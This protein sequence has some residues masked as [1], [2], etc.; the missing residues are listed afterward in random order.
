M[1]KLFFISLLSS[2]LFS[3]SIIIKTKHKI[4]PSGLTMFRNH[5]FV[6]S[7]NGR[8]CDLSSRICKKFRKK[9]DFEGM[10][11]NGENIYLGVEGKD[12][13]YKLN[14]SM[15]IIEK[16]KIPRYYKG[17]NILPK[18]GDGIEGLTFLY[19]KA[20]WNYFAITNQSDNEDQIDRSRIIILKEKEISG[21]VRIVKYKD[22]EIT[23][24]SGLFVYKKELYVISDDNN[25]LMK[26]DKDLN[27]LKKWFL[28]G[29]DQ[30]GLVITDKFI[31]IAQDSGNVLKIKRSEIMK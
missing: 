8:L 29:E 16:I 9:Y 11:N 22:F 21:E 3:E 17:I 31:Y 2:L 19:K 28:P 14:D 15:E 13:I 4:E 7:D 10:T 24:L 18:G 5:L 6:I 1:K 25:Y 12:D 20:G 30:E 27:I 23:D 26:L